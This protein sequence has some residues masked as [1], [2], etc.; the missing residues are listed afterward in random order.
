MSPL[1]GDCVYAELV[2]GFAI[3]ALTVAEADDFEAHLSA[4]ATCGEDLGAVRAIIAS[5]VDWPSDLLR[6]PA[7]LWAQVAERIGG[8]TLEVQRQPPHVPKRD[9]AAWKDL[10]PGITC[11]L[12][13]SDL[14]SDRVSMLVRLAPGAQYPAHRHAGLEELHLLDGELSIDERKLLPGDYH[15]AEPG[16]SDM[17]VFSETGCTCLLFTSVK[18][19]LH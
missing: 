10:A 6:P 7:S 1:S 15:R 13:S 9:T 16:T 12:M 5:F 11:R 2:Y 8:G 17:R 4:C 14:A 3:G 18:D 19:R